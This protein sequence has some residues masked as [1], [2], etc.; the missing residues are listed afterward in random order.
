MTHVALPPTE[1]QLAE[2]E[3]IVMGLEHGHEVK[4]HADDAWPRVV[5]RKV[6][7]T[8]AEVAALD[9]QISAVDERIRE[10][11][12]GSLSRG[13]HGSARYTKLYFLQRQRQALEEMR[14]WRYDRFLNQR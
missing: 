11:F 8:W 3:M 4:R 13:P 2:L 14:A 10:C 9:R 1:E 6:P 12:G 5:D 7:P